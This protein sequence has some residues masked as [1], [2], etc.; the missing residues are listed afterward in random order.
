MEDVTSDI[1]DVTSHIEAVKA[2]IDA[3][4]THTAT[5][6]AHMLPVTPKP[7]F[8]PTATA[9]EKMAKPFYSKVGLLPRIH[10]N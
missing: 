8:E 5:V 7:P 3:A 10:I 9:P 2:H 4:T 6:I 1:E